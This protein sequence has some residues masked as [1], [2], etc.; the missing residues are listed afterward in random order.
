M[1]GLIDWILA[2][3]VSNFVLTHGWVWPAAETLHFIGLVLMAGTVGVF[4][5]RL[6]GVAKGI[7]P[8]ALH[9]LLRF[10]IAGFVVSLSTGLLFISGTPDQYFY[11]SAFH[12][13]MVC[14]LLTGA[15][16]IAFYTL[17]F[18][19]VRTLGAHDDAPTPAKAM[20][21]IS[22]VLLIAVMGCGRMLTFFRPP[23]FF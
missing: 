21:G 17:Q 22:F 9:R 18:A 11:N 12:L 16:V 2:T 19:T 15:N 14:L 8:F 23:G 1:T 5:L 13:K 6:L 4:D 10:G 7:P 3:S 20:A